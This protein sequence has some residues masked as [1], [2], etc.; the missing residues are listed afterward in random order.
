[1]PDKQRTRFQRSL[2]TTASRQHGVV[3]TRQLIALGYPTSTVYDWAAAG[4]LHRLHR[5]V[6]AVGH[7]HMTW[8]AHCFAAVLAN[9]PAVASHI[10]AAYL[11]GLLRGRPSGAFHVTARTRRHAKR[12]FR[13]HFAELA[14]EDEAVAEGIPVTSLSRTLLDLAVVLSPA[15]L[16]RVIGRAEELRLF[17]LRP[18]EALLERTKG[19]PGHGRLRRALEIYRDEPEFTRSRLERRFLRLARQAGIPAPAMNHVVGGFELDAYWEGERFAVELD[20]CETHGSHLSFESDRLR[21]DDL[22][23]IGVE[24][25]RVTG[26]RLRREP[27]ATIERVAAHLERRRRE[28]A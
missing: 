2:A 27:A 24:M 14:I 6:Y 23:L 19:H 9:A 20:I 21:Q 28:L 26:P 1:M 17:D 3:S 22:L 15:R 13:V 12:E 5:G 7:R 8:H 25:I 16:D 11:W 10:S 4:R 18:V